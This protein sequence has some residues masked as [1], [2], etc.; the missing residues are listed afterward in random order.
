LVDIAGDSPPLDQLSTGGS[1][2]PFRGEA[3]ASGAEAA[4]PYLTTPFGYS[5]PQLGDP[6][7]DLVGNGQAA[8]GGSPGVGE[9]I[10]SVRDSF[11][12][13]L[14]PAPAGQDNAGAPVPGP[15]P[16]PE[17]EPEPE[18]EPVEIT[19][20]VSNATASQ[21]YQDLTFSY[22]LPD[23]GPGSF[24]LVPGSEIRPHV[25]NV[26][27]SAEI[28]LQ[29]DG[30]GN[31][32]VAVTSAWDSVKNIKA[33]SATAGDITIENF[34][35]ADVD[36]GGGGD[37]SITI[38]GAKRGFVSTGDGNDRIEIE[39]YS[40]GD[41]WSHLFEVQAGDGDDTLVFDGA[42]NGLSRLHFDGGEGIDTLRLSG[43]GQ[44]FSLLPGGLQVTDVERIDIS[45]TGNTTLT[46]SSGNF[47]PSDFL[48][49]DGD[50]GDVLNLQGGGW[51][52]ADPTEIDGQSY[53]VYE[54]ASGARVAADV[55]VH[56]A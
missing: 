8:S 48:I 52:E 28:S 18:P 51:A 21:R 16:D 7:F 56:V 27:A 36:F 39:A 50:S 3:G 4:N 12:S 26:A 5:G 6:V 31:V 46:L 53:A 17:P 30:D 40:N 22:E 49:V 10:R 24:V 35:H 33:E 32:E 54:N 37:S 23:H 29:R 2:S 45:G 55:E 14:L 19:L 34:V 1:G 25:P 15:V 43:P 47:D 13:A 44:S 41:G 9:A 42:A 20:T 11:V 38:R